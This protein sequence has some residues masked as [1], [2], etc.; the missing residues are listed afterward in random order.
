MT[1]SLVHE[2]AEP[3]FLCNIST[4]YGSGD[5][6]STS[7]GI[8]H[9]VSSGDSIKVQPATPCENEPTQVI[10]GGT[11]PST[12]S[13][14]E[15]AEKIVRI[16]ERY[17]MAPRDDCSSRW[18]ARTLF[19]ERVVRS[20]EQQSEIR[21]SLPAFPFKSPNKVSKVLGSLPDCGEEIALRHLNGMCEAIGDV[22]KHGA[23]LY[24]VSDGLMYN[25][26][27]GVSD[28]EIWKYGQALR[29]LGE[30]HGCSNIRFIRLVDLLNQRDLTEPLTEA[31]YLRDAPRFRDELYRTYIPE[32]FDVDTHIA[33]EKDALLTYRGYLKFLEIDLE[34]NNGPDVEN[35]SRAQRKTKLENV[36]KMMIQRGKAFA[37]AISTRLSTY[38]RLSIH[39]STEATKLSISV[40]PQSNKSVMT[41]WHSSLVRALDG[42]ITMS[43]ALRVPAKTHNLIMENGSPSYFQERSPLFDW[44]MDVVFKY[45][46]PCGILVTPRNPFVGCSLHS[47]HMQKARALAEHCSPVVLRGF[48]DATDKH[49]FFAKAYDAGKPLSKAGSIAEQTERTQKQQPGDSISNEGTTQINGCGKGSSPTPRFRYVVALSESPKDSAPTLLASS[50]LFW[51]HLPSKFTPHG[52][53]KLT[54][55]YT[56]SDNGLIGS[57]EHPL[58]IPHPADN[59][60]LCVR[61]HSA[62]HHPTQR[63]PLTDVTIGSGKQYHVSLVESMLS[64]RRVSL[65][66]KWE[67][68]DVVLSDNLGMMHTGPGFDGGQSQEFWQ[69]DLN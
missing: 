35:M 58:V 22:Y 59:K 40:I 62:W 28:L 15:A 50:R 64:D 30:E 61:W 52:L 67:Q 65:Y 4:P 43:H 25:D 24:I 33:N 63:Y 29:K 3:I 54:W 31:E 37:N 69:V 36:A 57:E 21:I 46:Y 42:S 6:H 9:H 27:L 10:T 17:R 2:S 45:L 60:R 16:L 48:R 19:I 8:Q 7:N 56:T 23:K 44:S 68:G 11:L 51:Q 12:E 47:V 66:F 55:R 53:S 20:I 1:I 34:E 13:P 14:A 26:L 41:P 39:S 32:N 38:I 49:T 5:T 18:T